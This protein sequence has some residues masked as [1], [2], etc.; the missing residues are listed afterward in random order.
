MILSR[1]HVIYGCAAGLILPVLTICL[2]FPEMSR[3]MPRGIASAFTARGT[4]TTWTRTTRKRPFFESLVYMPHPVESSEPSIALAPSYLFGAPIDT[5]D[6]SKQ[7]VNSTEVVWRLRSGILF[8]SFDSLAIFDTISQKV[9]PRKGA[10][11]QGETII[12]YMPTPWFA[13]D[14]AATTLLVLVLQHLYLKARAAW[15]RRQAKCERCG[16]PVGPAAIC[17][18]CGT[19]K[20]AA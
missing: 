16:Y 6:L 2:S 15:R 9:T 5:I 10:V 3:F 1:R 11:A 8:A 13:A 18:E 20:P 4:D 17:P 7:D 14:V 19:G 12:P